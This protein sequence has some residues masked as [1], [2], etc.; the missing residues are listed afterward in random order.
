MISAGGLPPLGAFP[1]RTRRADAVGPAADGQIVHQR[2]GR[3]FGIDHFQMLD[4]PLFQFPAHDTCQRAHGGL[5]DVRDL[6]S[7][8]VHL[9]ASP[10]AADD[11]HPH[12]RYRT[13]QPGHGTAAPCPPVRRAA[14]FSKTERVIDSQFVGL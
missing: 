6:K 8:G 7:R 13:R 12:R 14:V 1:R 9:V 5:I 4:P 11:G 3:L 2:H 10:H